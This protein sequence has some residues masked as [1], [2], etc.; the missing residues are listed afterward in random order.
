MKGTEENRVCSVLLA[1][2]NK[3]NQKLMVLMLG[4]LGIQPTL[5]HNGIEA[6]D[7]A[8]EKRFDLI[9]MDVHMPGMNGL[10]ATRKIKDALGENSPSIIALTAD[11]IQSSIDKALQSGIDTYLIKPISMDMLKECIEKYG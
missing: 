6:V 1:E 11:V 8:L 3:I 9:L 2:D 10:E 7:L 4:K 5:A